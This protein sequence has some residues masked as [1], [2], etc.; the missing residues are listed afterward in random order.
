M[1]YKILLSLLCLFYVSSLIFMSAVPYT[2][3]EGTANILQ[4]ILE[5]LTLP[6]ILAVVAQTVIYGTLFSRR[7]SEKSGF[8]TP[9]IINVISLLIMIFATLAGL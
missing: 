2:P 7:R 1:N 3:S 4:G 5:L 9:L 6:V 8:L